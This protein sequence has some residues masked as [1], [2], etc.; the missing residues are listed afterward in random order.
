[1]GLKSLQ[2]QFQ[3]YLLHGGPTKLLPR[4]NEGGLHPQKRLEIYYDAYR[5]R[6]LEVL[7]LDYPK[8]LMLLGDDDFEA[9]FLK[10]LDKHPSM[11]FS[12]RYFG[13]HFP[14]FL[15]Q[16]PPFAEASLIAEMATFECAVS[17]TLDSE[18]GP[19]VTLED[20]SAISP[21]RWAALSFTL[22][23]SV[24]SRRF[25]WDTPQLWQHIDKELP[26]RPPVK[27]DSP[28]T[29]LFWRKGIRTLFQSCNI[30]ETI[31][32]EALIQGDTF[33]EMCEKLSDLVPEKDIPLVAAK[34]LYKW[35]SEEIISKVN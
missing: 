27:Q 28:V 24:I 4:V 12:V 21:S 26:P 15:E 25:E 7:S 31:L 11:H 2:A 34:T 33:A 23:P 29:W 17:Y 5:L 35:V 22:H 9:A 1:M 30:A 10:Y 18:D 14:D 8:T 6:L 13:Q 16:T 20:L 19:V 3:D 32:F